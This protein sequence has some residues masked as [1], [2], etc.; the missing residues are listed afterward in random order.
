[1]RRNKLCS[2]EFGFASFRRRGS[3]IAMQPISSATKNSDCILTLY[4][5]KDGGLQHRR[6][7]VAISGFST[8]KLSILL[9]LLNERLLKWM[10]EKI[11]QPTVYHVVVPL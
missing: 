8:S 1:M 7:Q 9:P 6:V 10:L 11:H 3:S 4:G 2:A 5:D